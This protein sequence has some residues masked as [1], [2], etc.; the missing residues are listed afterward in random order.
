MRDSAGPA[1]PD[2]ELCRGQHRFIAYW[3][4][5]DPANHARVPDV[6]VY[7]NEGYA[8][9]NRHLEA[10][11]ADIQK[12]D[13]AKEPFARL[14][15]PVLTVHGTLDRNAPYGAGLEWATTF[16]DGRLLTVPGGAHQVWLDD[17]EVLGDIDGFLAGRWPARAVRFGRD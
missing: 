10:H 4:V 12:R 2:I 13:F 7:P 17:P 5:G 9:Q 14:A 11:F 16:R 15:V 1:T 6:C 8:A 3:L